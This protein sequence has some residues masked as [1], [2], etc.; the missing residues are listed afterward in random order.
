MQ[1]YSAIYRGDGIVELFGAVN[2]PKDMSVFVQIPDQDDEVE[3][4]RQLRDA[5]EPTFATLWDNEEGEVWNEYFQ[6]A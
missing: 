1:T 6:T 4:K 2:L 3:M 5:A